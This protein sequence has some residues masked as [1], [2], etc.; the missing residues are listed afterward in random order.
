MGFRPLKRYAVK[1]FVSSVFP[2]ARRTHEEKG[3]LGTSRMCKAQLAPSQHRGDP[4]HHVLLAANVGFQMPSE[5]EKL[6]LPGGS[7][8]R[9]P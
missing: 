6:I 4:L 9:R 5:P 7:L 2:D 8:A 1:T 3:A